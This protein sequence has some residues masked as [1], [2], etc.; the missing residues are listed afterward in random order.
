VLLECSFAGGDIIS[1]IR[2]AHDNFPRCTF[3]LFVNITILKGGIFVNLDKAPAMKSFF[4]SVFIFLSP[5][6]LF[7]QPVWQ[8]AKEAN[9]SGNEDGYAI[10]AD[11]AGNT[12]VTGRFEGTTT[13]GSF[14]VTSQGNFDAFLA[15]YSPAGTCLWVRRMGGAIDDA[16]YG[17]DLDAAGNC[18]ITG[19]SAQAIFI[20]KYDSSG[21]QLWE[22]IESCSIYNDYSRATAREIPGLPATS[23][24]GDIFSELSRQTAPAVL[25]RGMTLT[26]M[27]PS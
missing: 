20:A 5:A 26:G 13:F 10:V 2:M 6:A 1:P 19:D 15:K 24:T 8:W 23:V 22:K 12:Y 11:P 21:N 16:G 7:S 14:S 18:Y 4:L 27:S 3:P 25:S 17:V 9:S